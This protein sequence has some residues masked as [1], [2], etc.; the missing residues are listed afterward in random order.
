M[1]QYLVVKYGN[2]LACT[3]TIE[4]AVAASRLLGG[5][6]VVEVTYETVRR[7]HRLESLVKQAGL[8]WKEPFFHQGGDEGPT[9]EW[10]GDPEQLIVYLNEH[11]YIVSVNTHIS[12]MIDGDC[13][14]ELEWLSVWKQLIQHP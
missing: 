12:E 1:H 5:G 6:E 7:W 13:S 2:P 10:W 8:P 9:L 14:S 11:Y 4:A 3:T